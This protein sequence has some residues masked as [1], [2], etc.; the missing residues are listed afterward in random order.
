MKVEYQ[1]DVCK[2]LIIRE[3][4]V[5]KVILKKSEDYLKHNSIKGMPISELDMCPV[6]FE[7]T[8]KYI[9]G[10]MTQLIPVK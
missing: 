7:K 9:S 5:D 4:V 1:C 3:N 10:L 2:S 6:C 8:W